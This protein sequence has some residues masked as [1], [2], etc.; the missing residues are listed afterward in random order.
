MHALAALG[1]D[2]KQLI[3]DYGAIGIFLIVFAESGMLVGFFLPGDSMLFTAGLLVAT[4][5]L[6]TNIVVLLLGC[7][8]AAVVGDQVGYQIGHAAGPRL[9]DRPDSR[10]FKKQYV[11]QAQSFFDR[12]GARTIVLA[13]FVPIVRTFAPVVAGVGRMDRATF[14]RYNLAGGLL[15]AV[16]VTLAG[17]G[18]GRRFEWMGDKIEVLSLVIIAVS[19]LPMVIEVVRHR[20]SRG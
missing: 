10:L 18:L 11:E 9:F 13:R 1:L 19:V 4:G 6:H 17:W 14:T 5:V 3:A 12:H 8:V 20:R 7:F 2:P 15:W 16:G